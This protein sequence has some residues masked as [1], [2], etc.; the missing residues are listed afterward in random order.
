M[1][2]QRFLVLAVGDDRIDGNADV[3]FDQVRVFD[4]A[5]QRFLDKRGDSP[6]ETARHQPRRRGI[7][8]LGRSDP[9][10]RTDERH[11]PIYSLSLTV[12]LCK[13]H[14]RNALYNIPIC[15]IGRL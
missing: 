14:S 5:A 6:E 8:A 13:S 12:F 7:H 10:I 9:M 15:R 3:F 1:F 2:V 11:Q 4:A